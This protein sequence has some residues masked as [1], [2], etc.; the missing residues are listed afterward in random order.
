M[1]EVRDQASC[2]RE[3]HSST[4]AGGILARDIAGSN[5][6]QSRECVTLPTAV[7][8]LFDRYVDPNGSENRDEITSCHLITLYHLDT[9]DSQNRCHLYHQR[10]QSDWNLD[11]NNQTKSLKF[12]TSEVSQMFSAIPPSQYKPNSFFEEKNYIDWSQFFADQFTLTFIAKNWVYTSCAFTV[13]GNGANLSA[14]RMTPLLS[15]WIEDIFVR[16]KCK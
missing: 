9:E 3:I 5:W 7:S 14:I 16:E 1:E 11:E 10:S 8:S 2:N 12:I 4:C 6:V 13:V 15:Y